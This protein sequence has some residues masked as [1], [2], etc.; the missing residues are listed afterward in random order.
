MAGGET[1]V[2]CPA[3]GWDW[4]LYCAQSCVEGQTRVAIRVNPGI[5]RR[6]NSMGDLL[7]NQQPL[8]EPDNQIRAIGVVVDDAL[9]EHFELEIGDPCRGHLVEGAD[10]LR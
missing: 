6:G 10:V 4:P 5:S 3:G 1:L 7:E 2:T 8:E 9:A